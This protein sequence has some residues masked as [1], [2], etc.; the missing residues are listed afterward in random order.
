[1]QEERGEEVKKRASAYGYKYGI[2]PSLALAVAQAESSFD[3][4]AVSTDGHASKGLFQLL[5]GTGKELLEK[6]SPDKEYEPFNPEQNSELGISYL[7]YLHDI[8]N[9]KSDLTKNKETTPAANSASL[10]KLAVAAFNA[11]QGR[12]ASAQNAAKNAGL[13]PGEY[14][15][16]EAYLPESTQNY[17]K[18]VDEIK[19]RYA[20]SETE[21]EGS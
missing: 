21:I 8:F 16:I 11:G 10:E 15:H 12:V 19:A 2:D 13:N 18:K 14:T 17:V 7:R 1:T 6:L 9:S 4:K 3:P 5:D 20:V